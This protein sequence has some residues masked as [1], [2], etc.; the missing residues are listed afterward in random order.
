M[1][2]TLDE[3]DQLEVGRKYHMLTCTSMRP[4]VFVCDCGT[5]VK[6]RSFTHLQ[7]GLKSCGCM[8]REMRDK[9]IDEKLAL[10]KLEL[11]GRRP[12]EKMRYTIWRVRCLRCDSVYELSDTHLRFGRVGHGCF[13]C[14]RG[15]KRMTK[16]ATSI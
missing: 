7:N 12:G 13:F 9:R 10:R 6:K 15:Y 8:S 16:N 2:R 4:T 14:P 5:V 3:F 1:R 11:V